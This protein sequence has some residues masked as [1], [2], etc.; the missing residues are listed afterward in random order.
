MLFHLFAL[1]LMLPRIVP[2]HNLRANMILNDWAERPL[3]GKSDFESTET[4][5][6]RLD[7][8]AEED[9]HLGCIG[10]QYENEILAIAV[11]DKR[12][13]PH[14]ID[15][16]IVLMVL[17]SKDFHSGSSLLKAMSNIHA[18]RCS[19]QLDERWAIAHKFFAK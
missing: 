8:F 14:N 6:R 15:E 12:I 3:V 18:I 1:T 11:F 4:K 19:S 13:N 9:R 5:K 17:D 7:I 10:L 16:D 2:L